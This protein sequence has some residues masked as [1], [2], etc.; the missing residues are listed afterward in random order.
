MKSRPVCVLHVDDEPE[1]ADLVA[2]FL[3]THHSFEVLTETHPQQ[4]LARLEHTHIDCIVSDYEMP[5]MTG[6]ELLE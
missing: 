5:G 2:S 1:F 6:L 3:S 4:A